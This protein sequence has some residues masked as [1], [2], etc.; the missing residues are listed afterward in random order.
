VDAAC[1]AHEQANL[2]DFLMCLFYKCS[3]D[4]N[5][6]AMGGEQNFDCWKGESGQI[7]TLEFGHRPVSGMSGIKGRCAAE[8]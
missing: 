1:A 3:N 2:L 8:K 4:P 6:T 5:A 7:R